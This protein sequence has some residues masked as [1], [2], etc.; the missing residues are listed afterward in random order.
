M[1]GLIEGRYTRQFLTDLKKL[2]RSDQQRVLKSIE[3]K[4]LKAPFKFGRKP[5]AKKGPGRWRFRVGNYRV[6]FDIE[7]R[8]LFFYRV[9]H[10]RAIYE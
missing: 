1:P 8:A 7:G 2:E 5:V 4:L 10:R 9:R 6:R 3:N